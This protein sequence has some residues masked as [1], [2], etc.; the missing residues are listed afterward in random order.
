MQNKQK[1]KTL[2]MLF[3]TVLIFIAGTI[4]FVLSM[5]DNRNPTVSSSSDSSSGSSA[6]TSDAAPEISSSSSAEGENAASDE[7]ELQLLPSNSPSWQ[8]ADDY[9]A[10][11]LHENMT[12]AKELCNENTKV[13]GLFTFTGHQV[14]DAGDGKYLVLYGT[15]IQYIDSKGWMPNLAWCREEWTG[16][17]IYVLDTQRQVEEYQAAWDA[18]QKILSGETSPTYGTIIVNGRLLSGYRF[19]EVDGELYLPLSA[20]AQAIDPLTFQNDSQNRTVQFSVSRPGGYECLM[21]P[22]DYTSIGGYHFENQKFTAG[23]FDDSIGETW[24]D[25]FRYGDGGPD[26]YVP[27]SELSRYTGWY[28]YAN[29]NLVS[30]VSS[31]LD[32]TDKFVLNT[33][34]SQSLEE[35]LKRG[36][37]AEIIITD[38]FYLEN[39]EEIDRLT[40][41]IL[42]AGDKPIQSESSSAASTP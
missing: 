39:K 40:E 23:N 15:E 37:S 36:D 12:D 8:G 18:G 30:V 34:G 2:A 11:Q 7:K 42:A 17:R 13:E 20:I 32:V 6:A 28:I 19:N 9:E 25:S 10:P 38:D 16:Q 35:Q 29:D 3:L 4:F 31:D 1:R 14:Y 24:S 41:E 21:V 5:L 22:Y 26:C 33:Q 27:A